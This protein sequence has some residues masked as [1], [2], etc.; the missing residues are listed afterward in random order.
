MPPHLII[1]EDNPRDS[2]FLGALLGGSYRLSHAA[3]GTEALRLA[4]TEEHPLVLSDIQMPAVNG[5]DLAKQL[6]AVRPEAVIV[7]WS[8]YDDEMYVRALAKIIPPETVY[9]YVLKS[10]RAEILLKALQAVF[11]EGQ[12]WIDPKVRP[13]Q[14]RLH[15]PDSALSD[16]EYEALLD[17]ALGLTDQAIAERRFLSRRGAQNRLQSLYIKL[18][19]DK[20]PNHAADCF[21]PRVRAL[22]LALRRGL[23]N[24][25]VLEEEENKLKKW[26]E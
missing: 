1:A 13:V 8:H 17:L 19:A 5:I 4:A 16:I 7:F 11:K 12:C 24:P 25:H 18:G 23:I 20:E 22:S 15:K 21:N 10:N 2:D 6:W 3:S 26:L 14:A 9:G